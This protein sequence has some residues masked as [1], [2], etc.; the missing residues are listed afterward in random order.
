MEDGLERLEAFVL[1]EKKSG[2]FRF[3]DTPGMADCMLV[4][5]LYN[6]RRLECDLSAMPTL[7]MI[8]AHCSALEAFRR[9]HPAAQPDAE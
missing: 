2:D 6:A 9:A 4:P 3:G 8:D 7:V 5:Q 1:A